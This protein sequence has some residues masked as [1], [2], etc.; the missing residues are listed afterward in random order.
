[1]SQLFTLGSQS[2]EV[3]A[4]AS[5]LPMNIQ[6]WFPLRLTGL[7]WQS[8]G[9]SG[10]LSNTT[11]QKHQFFSAQPSLWSNSH[12]H[13]WP[14]EKLWL[15]LDGPLLAKSCL[16]VLMFSVLVAAFLPRSNH[17]LI[18]W[19]QSPSAVI[20][21]SKKINSLTVPIVS[22]SICHEVM[23][24]DAMTLVFWMLSLKPAF[25]LSSFTFIKRLLSS[26]LLSAKRVASSAIWGYWYFCRQ[27]WFQ[28]VLHSAQHFTWCTL[29][30]S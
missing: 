6:D 2:T 13:I 18:S 21:E 29:H 4:S 11:V 1:M 8:K 9:L 17:L 12:I 16:C 14:L 30:R 22:P 5:V 10:V 19:L 27:Y 3:S 25:P 23:W 7:I 28:L 24:L 15:W 20:L 26:S